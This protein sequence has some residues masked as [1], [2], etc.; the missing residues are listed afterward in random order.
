MNFRLA[1]VLL[2]AGCE[3]TH[4]PG[5]I[6]DADYPSGHA[7]VRNAPDQ[8]FSS[9]EDEIVRLTN[10]ARSVPMSRLEQLDAVARG[11]STHM[12]EHYFY[13]HVDPEGN[14]P[15]GRLAMVARGWS[16]VAENVWIVNADATAQ[17]IFDGFMASPDHRDNILDGRLDAFGVGV[18]LSYDKNSL[19]VTME[20]VLRK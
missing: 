19:Y 10:A 1:L 16:L 18:A 12:I 9:I 13:G 3:S 11:Y 15:D 8:K 6:P 20:F 14:G 2:L 5:Y 7:I 17:Y 4:F